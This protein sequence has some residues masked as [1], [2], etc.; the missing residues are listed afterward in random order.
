MMSCLLIKKIYS[1]LFICFFTRFYISIKR[2][3]RNLSLEQMYMTNLLTSH[4]MSKNI[5]QMIKLMQIAFQ[6]RF[7][8]FHK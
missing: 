8:P 3:D 5:E 7:L 1:T 6:K 2:R 4:K